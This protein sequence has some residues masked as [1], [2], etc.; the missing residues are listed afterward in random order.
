[1]Q[2]V[3]AGKLAIQRT[4]VCTIDRGVIVSQQISKTSTLIRHGRT[5]LCAGSTTACSG[6]GLCRNSTT[7]ESRSAR[8]SL[9]H[10]HGLPFLSLFVLGFRAQDG[11]VFE[12][13]SK[14]L[15]KSDRP[16]VKLTLI[17]L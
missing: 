4:H 14:T 9:V 5:S 15:V 2:R 6:H 3:R 17:N 11:L 8:A 13:L 7:N 12:I 1:M 10:V 16:L